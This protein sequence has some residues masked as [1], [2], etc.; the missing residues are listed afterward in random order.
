MN[1]PP[2]GVLYAFGDLGETFYRKVSPKNPFKDFI[3]LFSDEVSVTSSEIFYFVGFRYLD[4]K[5]R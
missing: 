3:L 2:V 5:K 1:L 4:G